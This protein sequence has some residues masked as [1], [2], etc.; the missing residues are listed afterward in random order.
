M[1]NQLNILCLSLLFA[2]GAMAQPAEPDS[3][4]TQELNEVVVEAQLQSTS[5]TVSTYIPTSKQKNSSQT[6][7]DLLNRMAIPQL[8]PGMGNSVKTNTG[9]NVDIYI[10]YLPAS[11]QEINGMRMAD[12]KKVEYY[13]YPKDPR[14]QGSAH[15]INFIMQ[16]YEYGGYLKASANEFF[17]ANSGQLNLY[18]KFQYKKMTYDLGVGGYYRN[19]SHDFNNT[20]ETY[21]LPQPDGS[22]KYFERYSITNDAESR[23][24]YF[25]P[26]FKALYRTGKISL[27]NTIGATFDNY[28]KENTSGSV[29]FSPADFQRSDLISEANHRQNYI[30]YNGYWNF[31]LPHGNTINFAPYYSYSH[32]K[33]NSRYIE[34]QSSE[35]INNA[36]DNT[37]KA[38]GNL[39]FQH[40][41]GKWGDI[42]VSTQGFYYNSK[43]RYS[44]TSTSNDRLTVLRLG[45]GVTY[46]FTNDKFYASAGI[47]ISYDRTKSGDITEE[48]TYPWTDFS[49]QYSF[50]NKNSINAEFHYSSQIPALSARS[51]AVIQSN[52]LMSYTG[53]PN[54]KPYKCYDFGISYQW[55][56]NNKFNFSAFATG[57]IAANRFAYVYEASADGILRT[58]QQPMGKFIEG[59]YGINGTARL[60]DSDLQIN[61]QLAHYIAKNEE[62][63]SWTK[64]H[65]NWYLQAFYYLNQ[66][67]FGLQYQSDMSSAGDFTNG[68]WENS[69]NA[70]TA[71]VGWGNSSWNFQAQIANPFRWNWSSGSSVMKSKN[72]DFVQHTFS[73]DNHC[74][75]YVTATYTFGFGK[76]IKVGNEASQMS[77]AGSAILK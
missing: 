37:H 2:G 23:R 30:T 38:S 74:F 45:P 11:E 8:S 6:A 61:G 50:N 16:K 69:K 35:Y 77:G 44:G 17:I 71:I 58:V 31:I 7:T 39:R 15:V 76:K 46:N 59:R 27:S 54:L 66:W 29:Y 72:Y 14:F 57:F 73:P 75:V 24:R 3:I 36:S 51:S 60:L 70:Y 55:L 20:V 28:P 56:P 26:T 19:G 40:D 68:V 42:T 13:D 21:R 43:T 10:D 25:W 49:A 12:V 32:S 63:F 67:H 34:G 53:N 64:S 4:E 65:L 5:A 33:Q 41:F 47:G 1:S 9:K 18:S 52:P 48:S 62:P 22:I